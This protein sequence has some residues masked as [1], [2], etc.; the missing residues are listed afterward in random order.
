[1]AIINLTI[2]C[3]NHT[4]CCVNFDAQEYIYIFI[5]KLNTHSSQYNK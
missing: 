2:T 4:E 1:M 3:C 5:L